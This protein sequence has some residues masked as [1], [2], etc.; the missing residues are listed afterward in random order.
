MK[1]TRIKGRRFERGDGSKLRFGLLG[2]AL[3]W[4]G[5]QATSSEGLRH[6]TIEYDDTQE[7]V[8]LQQTT[9]LTKYIYVLDL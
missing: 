6:S 1:T 2:S 3:F 8:Y 5:L 4:G 7:R 9:T